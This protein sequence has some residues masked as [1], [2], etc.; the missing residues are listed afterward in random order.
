MNFLD[1]I[2]CRCFAVMPRHCPWY[3]W[4]HPSASQPMATHT[5]FSFAVLQ[6]GHSHFSSSF[7]I[8]SYAAT[9]AFFGAG[10]GD[11]SQSSSVILVLL[12]NSFFFGLE[13]F[14]RSFLDLEVFVSSFAPICLVINF[15]CTWTSQTQDFQIRNCNRPTLSSVLWK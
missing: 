10:G 14:W 7:A 13:L 5:L 1:D 6:I 4:L 15:F 9:L 12:K 8:V 3:H 11:R 2:F